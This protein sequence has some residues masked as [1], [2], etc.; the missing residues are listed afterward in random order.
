MGVP[1]LLIGIW[2]AGLLTGI[3]N[4]GTSCAIFYKVHKMQASIEN[5]THE[6]QD[7]KADIKE[8]HTDLREMHTDLKAD[9]VTALTQLQ[10]IQQ[11]QQQLMAR[12]DQR[13]RNWMISK[14]KL[15]QDTHLSLLESTGDFLA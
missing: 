11:Q 9:L 8:M 6:V 15:V 4:L 13:H 10:S 5:L 2:T 1:G 3:L 7:V 14:W 12:F